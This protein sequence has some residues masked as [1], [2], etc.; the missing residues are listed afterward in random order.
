MNAIL[1]RHRFLKSPKP[2]NDLLARV[3]TTA[4]QTYETGA[5]PASNTAIVVETLPQPEIYAIEKAST[6]FNEDE[7]E[8]LQRKTHFATKSIES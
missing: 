5:V 4:A 3:S 6:T 8:P 1:S 2:R 7:R